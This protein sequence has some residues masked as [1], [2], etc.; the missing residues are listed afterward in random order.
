MPW[1]PE[2]AEI[3]PLH[4]SSFGILRVAEARQGKTALFESPTLA[5]SP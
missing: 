1:F 4:R 5:A 2:C 3:A